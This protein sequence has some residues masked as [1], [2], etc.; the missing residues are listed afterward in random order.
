[1]SAPKWVTLPEYMELTGIT[2][3]T[4]HLLEKQNKVTAVRTEGGHWRIM[5]DELPEITELKAEINN[6]T[7][8]VTTLCSHFGVKVS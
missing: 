3:E 8:I 2:R 6:L 4:F 1:M 7:E 5:I